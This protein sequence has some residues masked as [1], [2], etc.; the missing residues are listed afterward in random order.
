MRYLTTAEEGLGEGWKEGGRKGGL[1]MG[2]NP[3][4][5]K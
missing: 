5:R 1:N 2:I 4:S 3:E